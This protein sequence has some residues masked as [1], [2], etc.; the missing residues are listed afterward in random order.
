MMRRAAR[1]VL[2]LVTGGL[3]VLAALA[4][5]VV[6]RIAEEPVSVDFLLPVLK[7]HLA[8]LPPEL[9]F[10]IEDLVIAWDEDDRSVDLRATG[11]TIRARDGPVLAQFPA[12]DVGVGLMPLAHGRLAL[13]AIEIKQPS[14]VL[15]RHSDGTLTIMGTPIELDQDRADVDVAAALRAM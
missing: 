1:A 8:V 6:W 11:V 12:V 7:P 15:T 2:R 14:L 10:E 9:D 3:I 4:V 5:L 13:T